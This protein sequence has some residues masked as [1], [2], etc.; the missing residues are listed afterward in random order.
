[1]KKIVGLLFISMIAIGMIACSGKSGGAATGNGKAASGESVTLLVW[2]MSWGPALKH[3]AAFKKLVQ[4]FEAENPDIKIEWQ[5]LSW[6]GYLENFMT[7]ITTGTTPDVSTGAGGQIGL[8]SK[9]DV[10]LDLQPIITE[11]ENEKNPILNDIYSSAFDSARFGDKVTAFVMGVA[12]KPIMYRADFFK[13][14]GV[15]VSKLKTWE[16]YMDALRK[17]KK[18]FPDK[19]PIALSANGIYGT[20][21]IANMLFANEVGWVDENYQPNLLSKESLEMLNYLKQ[22]VDEELIPAGAAGYQ[23]GDILKLFNSGNAA[24]IWASTPAEV[25]DAPFYDQIEILPP[26]AG[27]SAKTGYVPNTPNQIMSFKATRHP[28]ES[29]R[30]IKWFMENSLDYFV[31][32]GGANFPVRPSFHEHPYYKNDLKLTQVNEWVVKA[33]KSETFPLAHFYPA[34][35][36]LEGEYIPGTVF[37][38]ICLGIDPVKA[39]TEGNE[40]IKRAIEE[41]N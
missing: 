30:F 39:A 2:E 15:D 41:Y 36:Q 1:M 10:L 12:P 19:V 27:P 4:R 3:E 28:A 20:H 24:C 14:A 37:Q 33:G 17:C 23:Y 16:D 29:R 5:I 38:Q 7:A 26:L 6:D 21:D 13:E 8:Y 9:M 34:F 32:Y 18:T 11:W 40:K 35:L 25:G 31:E 22:M